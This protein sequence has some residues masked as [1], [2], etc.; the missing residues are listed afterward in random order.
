MQGRPVSQ[1]LE[2]QLRLR[3]M[4]LN[5][6]LAPGERVS[7]LPLVE[8]IGVSRTPLRLALVRLEH[9]GLLEPVPGGGFAV[10][11]FA[12]EE[13]VDAIELRGVLEGTAARL[14]A[15][16]LGRRDELSA[17]RACTA[18]L[19]AVVHGPDGTLGAF[20]DYVGL[21]E[22]FHRLLLD[23]AKS[24]ALTRAMEKVVTLP[25]ASPAAFLSAHAIL[26]RSREILVIAQEHHRAIVEAIEGREGARAEALAREHARIARRNLEVVREDQSLIDALPGGALMRLRDAG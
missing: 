8:R 6:T 4:I 11:A 19:D 15:E 2:A 5:G 23:L 25:F 13:I 9:E 7:E 22:R 17:I 12:Y 16:R 20:S 24:T 3:E 21:N 26:P 1:S 18:R 10:K 14:A